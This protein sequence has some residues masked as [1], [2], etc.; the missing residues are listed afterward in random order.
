MYSPVLAAMNLP[1]DKLDGW[2]ARRL[3]QQCNFGAQLD[4]LA[5]SLAFVAAPALATAL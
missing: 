2:L 5:D 4:S 3:K 1:S